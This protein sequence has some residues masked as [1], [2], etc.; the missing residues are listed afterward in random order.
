MTQDTIDPP[1]SQGWGYGVII[2]IGIAFAAVMMGIT[3][4]LRKYSHEDNANFETYSTAGRSVKVGLTATAVISSWAWSTALLSSGTV[5]YSYGIGG[6]FWFGAGCIVQICTFALLAIQSK[7]KTPHAHTILEVVKTR[8]GTMAHMVYMTLCLINNLI[9]VVN[10]LLGASAAIS[11]LTGMHVVA[12]IFLLPLGVCLYT[13][14]GGLRAT[15]ITDWAHTVA[16]FIIVL[17]LSLKTLTSPQVGSLHD[18]W[19]TVIDA[20][21]KN[22]VEGNYKGSYATMTSPSA[23]E[24]G[25]LHTLGNFGL[26]IMDSSYWQKAYS[27]NVAAAVPGYLLGGLIYF[28]LP[29]CLGSVMGIGSLALQKFPSWPAFGR[30]LTNAELNAG[31]IL[32]YAGMAV[33]GK[34]GAVAVVIVVF[35][36]VTSTMSAEL[37]AVS[38]IVSTDVYYTYLHRNAT[39]KQI[40]WVSHMAC[41]LFALVG[42][43]VSVAVYYAGVSLTWTLYFLGVITCP[44]MIT[45]PLT[46]LW[47][48][49]SKVAAIVSP[50]LGMAGGLATWIT[51]AKRYGHGVISVETTGL[52]LPCLWGSLVSTVVPAIFTVILSFLFPSPPFHWNQFQDIKLIEETPTPPDV[53]EKISNEPALDFEFPLELKASPS[54][55]AKDERYMRKMSI[56]SGIASALAFVVI[57]IIWPFSMYASRFIFSPGFFSGWLVVSV[58][59]VFAGFL[60]ILILPPW[61][62]RRQIKTIVNG[63]L[64][65]I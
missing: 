64:S 40:M 51:T 26:V 48:R 16:L 14:S 33:A 34:A 11:A 37:I 10:M 13:I 15:F 20:S 55:S 4:L 35:M 25:I 42:C 6:A 61:D 59:W 36:A 46:V 5:T 8:Y 3:F 43:A 45:M 17:Y 21:L 63:L 12:S 2:G 23:V 32:P 60:V 39:S 28:G 56:V 31:L 41:V 52:L 62:G 58:I 49:Q 9:A 65:R 54:Q 1:L 38:S 19:N 22:P 7:L 44:G 24:F 57:W 29:W 53:E 30:D 27:A 18:L 47:S 50:L